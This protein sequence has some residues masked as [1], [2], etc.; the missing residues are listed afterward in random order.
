VN[1]DDI[2]IW[3]LFVITA[4]VVVATIEVGYLLGKAAHR[5]SE[6][7]KESPVSAIAGTVLALLAFMLAFTFGFVANKYDTRRELVRDQ[8]AAVRTSFYRSDFLPEPSRDEAKTLYNNYVALLIEAGDPDNA[9]DLPVLISDA[10]RI[11]AQLWGMAVENVRLGDNSDISA[12]YVDSLNEMSNVLANRIAIAVQARMPTGFWYLLYALIALGMIAVGYQTA[13]AGSR[14]T[15]VMVIMALSFSIVVALIAALDDPE[16]GYLPV[17]QQ[18]MIDLQ[19]E[20]QQSQ[21][22]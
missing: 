1:F 12:M 3:L 14:R 7:E 16:R 20:M 22:P 18:P 11:Q 15:W 19:A 4:L 21:Q 8:A 9:D 2:S 5:R 17:S 6:D 13:I 10:H